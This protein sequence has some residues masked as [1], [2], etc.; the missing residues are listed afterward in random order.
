MFPSTLN[1]VWA[2]VMLA[3]AVILAVPVVQLSKVTPIKTVH[4]AFKFTIFAAAFGVV[5]VFCAGQAINVMDFGP[6]FVALFS[7]VL[8]LNFLLLSVLMLR[9]ANK[10]QDDD[11]NPVSLQ[12]S[13]GGSSC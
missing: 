1:L 5:E 2:A 3:V 12:A 11:L 7:F 13:G 8:C 4:D 10:P 6:S 9:A